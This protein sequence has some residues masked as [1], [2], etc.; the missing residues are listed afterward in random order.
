MATLQRSDARLDF[1]LPA[2]AKALIEQAAAITCQSVSDFAAST[3]V[4]T[5]RE[6]VA[7]YQE[8]RLSDRD[9]DLFLALLDADG[10]PNEALKRAAEEYQ[11]G[12]VE[13]SRY[14]WSSSR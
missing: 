5:A 4:R 3:L 7:R 11:A 9:R 8:T 10:E 2:E 12:H 1:R 13:G 14:H 6:I